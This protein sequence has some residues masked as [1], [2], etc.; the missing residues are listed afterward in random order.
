MAAYKSL[1]VGHEYA[2]P[3]THEQ[4]SQPQHPQRTTQPY[5]QAS[6][7]TD[8]QRNADNQPIPESVS[9]GS[10]QR[11]QYT[12][13]IAQAHYPAKFHDP[14]P[15]PGSNQRQEWIEYLRPNINKKF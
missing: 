15:E 5:Q 10:T 14:Q 4:N 1:H 3:Q 2:R 7:S 6:G 11:S 13:D 12:H 8:K 9:Q